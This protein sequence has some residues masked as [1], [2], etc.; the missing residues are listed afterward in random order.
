MVLAH[1]RPGTHSGIGYRQSILSSEENQAYAVP[2]DV[3]CLASL[4]EDV[5]LDGVRFADPF[6][7]FSII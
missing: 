5:S 1:L 6:S 2:Y 7:V 3:C 4:E